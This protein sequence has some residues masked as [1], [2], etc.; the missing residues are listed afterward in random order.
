MTFLGTRGE[1]NIRS[2]RH[3][4]HSALLVQ[5]G[6]ARIMIDC[7]ADWLGTLKLIAPTAVVLTHAHPDH[8]AGLA[9]G[10]PCPVYATSETWNFIHRFPIRERRTLTAKKAFSIEGARFTAFPVEHSI[11][12][13]TVGFRVATDGKSFFYVPDVARVLD[14]KRALRGI[15]LFIGDGA[16]M[17]RSMVRRRDGNLIGHAPIVNQLAWCKHAG[18]RRAIFTHCGSGIVR[19]DARKLNAKLRELGREHGID[20]HIA[21]DGDRLCFPELEPSRP[22]RR[23]CLEIPANFRKIGSALNSR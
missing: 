3:R 21:L 5:R 1:I 4:R 12:A 7:G 2:R 13:P 18:I 17:T 8:A 10:A 20:A 23:G 22:S 16:T 19:G 11:R 6:N 14:A 15:D 9:A